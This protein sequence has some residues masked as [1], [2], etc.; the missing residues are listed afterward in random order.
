MTV[1][2]SVPRDLNDRIGEL[3]RGSGVSLDGFV[4]ASMERRCQEHEGRTELDEALA[5]R[6]RAFDQEREASG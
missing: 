1:T 4:A 3:T 2:V 5:T 6:A